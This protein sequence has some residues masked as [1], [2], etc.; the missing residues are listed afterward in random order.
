[1][2]LRVRVVDSESRVVDL[3]SA[4]LVVPQFF[5]LSNAIDA[6]VLNIRTTADLICTI[7]LMT[8][9]TNVPALGQLVMEEDSTQRKGTLYTHDPS[10]LRLRLLLSRR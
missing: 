9:D 1:M 2:V 3:G 8:A 5:G 7:R 6:S 10:R 4:P